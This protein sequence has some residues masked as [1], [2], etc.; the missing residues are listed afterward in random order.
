MVVEAVYGIVNV[1]GRRVLG[2]QIQ[3]QVEWRGGCQVK[4]RVGHRRLLQRWGR[5][6]RVG[7]RLWR[8]VA[9]RGRSVGDV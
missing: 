4:C 7:G 6:R 8:E 1:K 9:D 5:K 3:Y 2:G